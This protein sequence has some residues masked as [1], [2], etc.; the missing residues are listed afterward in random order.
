MVTAEERHKQDIDNERKRIEEEY[1]E[2]L[3]IIEESMKNGRGFAR[4]ELKID[5]N[6]ASNIEWYLLNHNYSCKYISMSN[7]TRHVFDIGW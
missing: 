1:K 2:Y 6:G 5:L 3:A 4:V 7:D